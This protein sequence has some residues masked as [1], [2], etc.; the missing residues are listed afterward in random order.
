MGVVD[1]EQRSEVG[2]EG[3]LR[4]VSVPVPG[5]AGDWT[6]A[7]AGAFSGGA[8]AVLIVA[9]DSQPDERTLDVISSSLAVQGDAI[10]GGRVFD[11]ARPDHVVHAGNWWSDSEREWR[12]E[13]YLEIVPD[14]TEPSAR[15][16]EWLSAASL[17]IPRQ[18]WRAMGGFDDRYGSFLSDVDFCLRARR[19]GFKCLLLRDV[20]I[21]TCRPPD[22]FD[23][24]LQSER[25]QS[26]LL[27]AHRHG[28]PKGLLT[29]ASRQIIAQVAD[30]L[31]R[32]DFWADYGADIGS[33]R[34]TLWFLR[35]CI[36]ALHR[37]RLLH[38][39]RQTIRCA[40]TAA[41]PGHPS[42]AA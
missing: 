18:I 25:L 23:A 7:I 15:P 5:R 2:E 10:L 19:R 33:S 11:A 13:S 20:R 17:I 22:S 39:I 27:L 21:L 37:D 14:P 29:T 35:N 4:V 12:C 40:R 28:V 32:V 36:Q 9:E 24:V 34:R 38:A 42:E 30:E 16:A 31:E 6:H 1:S 3:S 8:A 26:T 41:M